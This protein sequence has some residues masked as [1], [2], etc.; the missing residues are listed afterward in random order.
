MNWE[1][2]RELW[3]SWSPLLA[4]ILGTF[5]LGLV[6][7]MPVSKYANDCNNQQSYCTALH[8]SLGFVRTVGLFLDTL[9]P[10]IAAAA[11]VAI[12]FFTYT[13]WDATTKMQATAVQQLAAMKRQ[14]DQMD[15][16]FVAA[17][18]PIL[19]VRGIAFH[20]AR[21]GSPDEVE[22]VIANRGGTDARISDARVGVWEHD[23]AEHRPAEPPYSETIPSKLIGTEIRDGGVSKHQC[24]VEKVLADKLRVMPTKLMH[25]YYFIGYLVYADAAKGVDEGLYRMAFSRI[26]EWGSGRFRER[27]TDIDYEYSA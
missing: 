22:F 17:H 3:K 20:E 18:P 14:A 12:G 10:W 4:V 13:L 6:F 1:R 11:T 16:E 8:V 24:K 9:P 5:A 26:Y 25:D 21:D 15:L 7:G 19:V 2:F 23:R 27:D